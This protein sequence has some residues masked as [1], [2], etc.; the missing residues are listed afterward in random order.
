VKKRNRQEKLERIFLKSSKINN[1]LYAI[2]LLLRFYTKDISNSLLFEMIPF[3]WKDSEGPT[4][5]WRIERE[6]KSRQNKNTLKD[7]LKLIETSKPYYIYFACEM[8]ISFP[9]IQIIEPLINIIEYTEGAE[10]NLTKKIAVLALMKIKKEQLANQ[11]FDSIKN[12]TIKSAALD[13]KKYTALKKTE[14]NMI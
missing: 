12:E 3:I 14:L 4:F 1:Q 6:I 8:L 10:N 7:L 11:S 2:R 13:L 9:D 5:R